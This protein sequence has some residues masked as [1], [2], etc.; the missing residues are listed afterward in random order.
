M[1]SNDGLSCGEGVTRLIEPAEAASRAGSG[2]GCL[3]KPCFRAVGAPAPLHDS[4]VIK[5]LPGLPAARRRATRVAVASLTPT[6]PLPITR[7][8]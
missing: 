8:D 7:Q 2:Y 6:V 5:A 4:L 3:S 1:N